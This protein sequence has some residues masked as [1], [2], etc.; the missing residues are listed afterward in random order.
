[1]VDVYGGGDYYINYSEFDTLLEGLEIDLEDGA[2]DLVY[3]E[4]ANNDG[5]I[6]K[7]DIAQYAKEI[8]EANEIKCGKG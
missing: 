1:M 5:G 3:N 4:I 7:E 2:R 8:A 6:S